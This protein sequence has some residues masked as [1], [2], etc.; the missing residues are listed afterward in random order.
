MR[1]CTISVSGID[2]KPNIA[3]GLNRNRPL[4]IP[5]KHRRCSSLLEIEPDLIAR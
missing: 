3:N 2:I 5:D 1:N 4:P